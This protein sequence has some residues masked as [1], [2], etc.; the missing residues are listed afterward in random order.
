M[1]GQ[2][3]KVRKARK[4]DL[5]ELKNLYVNYTLDIEKITPPRQRFYK[6][7]KINFKQMHDK[8][9][10][11]SLEDKSRFYLVALVENK[12]IG[13]ISGRIEIFKNPMY[14]DSIKIGNVEF[15]FISKK[16]RGKRISTILFKALV[17]EFKKKKC[18]IMRLEVATKNPA[19]KIYEKWGFE[20][21]AIKMMRKI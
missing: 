10:I 15:V 5:T 4:E 9:F 11:K 21:S 17:E 16:S 14:E 7:K 18:N 13:G 3:V 6:K 12:I 2:I 20:S 1:P 8:A 19:K